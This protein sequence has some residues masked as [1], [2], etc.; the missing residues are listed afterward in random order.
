MEETIKLRK[1]PFCG[2]LP[3][4]ETKK[5]MV[6]YVPYQEVEQYQVKCTIC[7]SKTK[8]TRHKQSIIDLWN[9]KSI[10]QI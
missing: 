4:F 1:C 2:G 3:V 8:L 9:G 6:R 5:V 10:K 7:L